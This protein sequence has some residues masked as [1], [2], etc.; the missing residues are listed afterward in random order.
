MKH[1]EL[2]P[3]YLTLLEAVKQKGL[4]KAEVVL[5]SEEVW[6][7]CP[8]TTKNEQLG[9]GTEADVVS[10]WIGMSEVS[11]E[12][13]MPVCA[14]L[15]DPSKEQLYL[16][17]KKGNHDLKGLRVFDQDVSCE[18][19]EIELQHPNPLSISPTSKEDPSDEPVQP[20]LY[21]TRAGLEQYLDKNR[22]SDSPIK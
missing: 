21:V 11:G 20:T 2:G 8:R 19:E 15:T 18:T 1:S 3:T 6:M 22:S 4:K 7:F 17:L 9:K 14:K 10:N 13:E 5:H 16:R 12:T